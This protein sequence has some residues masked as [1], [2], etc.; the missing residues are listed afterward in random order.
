MH[1]LQVQGPGDTWINDEI[2]NAT[3]LPDED[4]CM[5]SPVVMSVEDTVLMAAHKCGQCIGYQGEIDTTTGS[6]KPADID[7]QCFTTKDSPVPASL[8]SAGHFPN[9]H[10]LSIDTDG[11]EDLALHAMFFEDRMGDP[12]G[13]LPG[14]C[15]AEHEGEEGL[16]ANVQQAPLWLLG[17]ESFSNRKQLITSIMAS[18]IADEHA[19]VGITRQSEVDTVYPTPTTPQPRVSPRVLRSTTPQSGVSSRI[20]RSTTRSNPQ[21]TSLHLHRPLSPKTPRKRKL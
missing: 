13:K 16:E 5:Q 9:T 15:G 6:P 12:E 21:A 20:L 1:S 17:N 18:K 4:S 8:L 11:T 2:T 14:E 7:S 3:V 19:T 10:S